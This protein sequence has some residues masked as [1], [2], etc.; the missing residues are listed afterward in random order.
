MEKLYR[1]S[2]AAKILAV[3]VRTLQRWDVDGKVKFIRT[4][5]GKRRIS[6]REIQKI[7]GEP[8]AESLERKLVIYARVSSHEQ[9][10]K[11]D[12]ERQVQIVRR[13][14]DRSLF[15]SIDIVEDVGSGLN[16]K[17]KGL[18]KLLTMAKEK[19]ITDVAVRYKD[20]LT[21]F[22]FEYL[23]F[24]FESHDVK[25]HVLDDKE[26]ASTIQEELVE[27]LLSIVTSFSGKLYGSRSNK[28]TL[29]KEKMKG[30]I[31]DVTNLPDEVEECTTGSSFVCRRLPQ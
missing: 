5:N 19:Q 7:L 10:R 6:E 18:L 25:L 3:S 14:I 21:R 27:D 15:S 4:P 12:L 9:K 1:L 31:E 17:R 11:G 22:G 26:K 28:N 8:P 2:E 13:K 16:D 29:M 30:V 24:Y 20:R 23:Q